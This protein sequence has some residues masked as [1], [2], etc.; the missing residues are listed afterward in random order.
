MLVMFSD[1]VICIS[2]KFLG[3]H[4]NHVNVSTCILY[5]GLLDSSDIIGLTFCT[6]KCTC[7]IGYI[8]SMCIS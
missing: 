5:H 2:T 1:G 7:T 8:T 4:T 3:K 6:C